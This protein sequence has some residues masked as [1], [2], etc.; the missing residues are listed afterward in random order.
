MRCVMEREERS[1]PGAGS[2]RERTSGKRTLSLTPACPPLPACAA[3]PAVREWAQRRR[4]CRRAPALSAAVAPSK[5]AVDWSCLEGFALIETDNMFVATCKRDGEWTAGEVKPYGNMAL[6]PAAG[7]LNYGQGVFEG[8]KAH[9]LE[10]GEIVIFR[11][12]DNA[13]RMQDGAA[14]MCMPAPPTELF[15]EAVKKTV[16]AN[17]RWVPPTGMGT[18]YIRPLLI[19]TG[20]ILGLAPAPEYTL[21]VYCSPVAAYFKGGQLTPIDLAIAD[22]MHRVGPGGTGGVK[23]IGNYAPVLQAQVRAKEG[24]YA[25]LM[26]LDAVHNKFVEEVSSCNVFAVKGKTI[27]TPA[28]KGTILPGIT[29]RSIIQLAR[30]NGFDV[31]EGDLPI[32]DLLAADEVFTTGTA[33]VVSSVGSMTYKGEKTLYNG[34][35]VGEVTQMLYDHLTQLQVRQRE[36]VHGW[37]ETVEC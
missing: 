3:W 30:D 16:A 23:S 31:V 6:S 12:E 13:A 33:V 26:Y 22:D 7:C 34:G 9:R 11:P 2:H 10:S 37:V 20:P 18:L 25:D 15:V 14:R 4:S 29:R 28:L 27:T 32:D 1:S 35:E 21:V 8:M 24:G 36:D 17:E 19:G 5:E